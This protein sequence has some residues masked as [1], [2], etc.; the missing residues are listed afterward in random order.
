MATKASVRSEALPSPS[1]K[2]LAVEATHGM[3]PENSELTEAE[4]AIVA[5]LNVTEKDYASAKEAA[6]AMSL[7][8]VRKSM[9]NVRKVHKHDANFPHSVLMKIE[10]FLGKC[11]GI[12]FK[13]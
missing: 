13:L 2:V 12:R 6:E 7:E 10:E 1:E 4:L 11:P 8:E 3:I 5:K 9:R